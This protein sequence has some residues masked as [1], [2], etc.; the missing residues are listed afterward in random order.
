[1]IDA[2]KST[3]IYDETYWAEE[4]HSSRERA[5]GVSLVRAGEAILY[6]RRP[7]KRFLDVGTGPGYLLD[8]LACHFPERVDMFYGVELFPP[9]VHSRHPNYIAGDVG[10]LKLRFDVGVCIE[11]VEH[12]TPRML[13]NVAQGLA[14]I[15]EPGLCGCSTPACLNSWSS[16]IPDIWIRCVEG[17][18]S[19]TGCGARPISS[20]R[21]DS[22]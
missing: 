21:S 14:G 11:V 15:S 19:R 13:G 12:L 9:D 4:L 2:G 10:G 8:T 20:S 6:A 17:I 5:D 3:R 1:M 7:V 16:R 18:S 22:G